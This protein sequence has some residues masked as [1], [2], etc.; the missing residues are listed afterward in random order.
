[1]TLILL[2]FHKMDHFERD[3]IATEKTSDVSK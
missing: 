1:M 2:T 3:V